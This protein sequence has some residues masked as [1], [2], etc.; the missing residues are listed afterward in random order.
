MCV[1]LCDCVCV[2]G[3]AGGVI[4]IVRGNGHNEPSSN[5]R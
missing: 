5:P 1:R 2:C 3:G 4:D